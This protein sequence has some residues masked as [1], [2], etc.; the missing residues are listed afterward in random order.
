[1]NLT[2]PPCK[3]TQPAPKRRPCTRRVSVRSSLP[4]PGMVAAL[5]TLPVI[6]VPVPLKHLDGVDS[7]HSMVQMPRGVPVNILQYDANEIMARARVVRNIVERDPNEPTLIEVR[8]MMQE[9][10]AEL[11]EEAL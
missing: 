11:I 9:A 7:L 8:E 4:L 2:L 10:E 1:M 5:T 3:R 6:G